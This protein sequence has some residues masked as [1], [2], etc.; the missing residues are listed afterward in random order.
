MA[1]AEAVHLI[2]VDR[3]LRQRCGTLRRIIARVCA[4]QVHVFESFMVINCLSG[5]RSFRFFSRRLAEA[6]VAA[7]SFLRALYCWWCG[8]IGLLLRCFW[9]NGRVAGG[10]TTRR[11]STRSLHRRDVVR[12][13]TIPCTSSHSE[14]PGRSTSCRAPLGRL[15][16]VPTARCPRVSSHDR[17]TLSARSFALR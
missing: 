6:T 1:L 3:T 13:I 11:K 4:V 5:F 8:S 9:G 17:T 12:A 15:R 10:T 14:E 16:R 2:R 7:S